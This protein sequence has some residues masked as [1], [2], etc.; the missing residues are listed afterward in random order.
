MK[1]R[2]SDIIDAFGVF[3]ISQQEVHWITMTQDCL[4]EKRNSKKCDYFTP[5]ER[6]FIKAMAKSLTV[7]C[8]EMMWE[9]GRFTLEHMAKILQCKESEIYYGHYPLKV[10][11]DDE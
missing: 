3:D 6:S 10:C 5:M 1:K 9:R 11:I 4:D 8:V 2:I 7:K